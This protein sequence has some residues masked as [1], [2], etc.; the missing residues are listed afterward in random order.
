M[1]WESESQR[2]EYPLNSESVVIDAGGY[3]GSFSETLFR[4]YGCT[5]HCFE[6]VFYREVRNRLLAY[7]GRIWTYPMA[8]GGSDRELVFRIKGD[9]TGRWADDGE[10]ISV[11]C[12]SVRALWNKLNLSAVALMKLNVE[13]ME[14]E[15]IDSLCNTG[16]INKVDNLQVQFHDVIG[17]D[18][19]KEVERIK[20]RLSETHSITWG[21]EWRFWTNFARKDRFVST[22][23]AGQDIFVKRIMGD[24]VGTFLD[25]G[26]SHPKERSNTFSLERTG[27]TGWLIDNDPGCVDLVKSVRSAKFISA[28]ATT[29]DWSFLGNKRYIDYLSLDIDAATL[30]CLQ[31]IPLDKIRFGII[32]VEHDRYRFGD[33]PRQQMR[34]IL[35]NAGYV[36][37]ASDVCSQGMQFEDWWVKPELE[38]K[39]SFA[40]SEGRE[41]SEI[42]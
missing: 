31:R 9:M 11:P 2:Y 42:V 22:S 28:D 23:Q 19:E 13:G 8:I 24:A 4:K 6:P 20:S 21:E 39:A 17:G 10:E 26:C 5:I 34:E 41:W 32:T 7:E 29:I 30:P 3:Q 38:E 36:R 35:S 15:I 25:V 16:L 1:K 14:Y 37:I 33:G 12:I 18:V 40:K 27:W